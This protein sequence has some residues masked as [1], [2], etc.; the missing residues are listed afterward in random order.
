MQS[1]DEFMRSNFDE[2]GKLNLI[3]EASSKD[4][5]TEFYCAAYLQK[6]QEAWN[7]DAK[8]QQMHPAVVLST[9]HYSETAEVI[10][11][12]PQGREHEHCRYHLQLT[13]TGWKIE[14]KGWQCFPC[15]GSNLSCTACDGVGWLYY[16]ASH[17]EPKSVAI[18]N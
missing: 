18:E 8:Y 4:F 17:L 14:R 11:S 3:Q 13:E 1:I 6:S 12:Q 16:G 5:R 2:W 9:E 15:K 10:V 7:E